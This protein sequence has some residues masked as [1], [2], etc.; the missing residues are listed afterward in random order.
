VKQS[1]TRGQQLELGAGVAQR[2]DQDR[3]GP[4]LGVR[5]QR[6][7][8]LGPHVHDPD[9][10]TRGAGARSTLGKVACSIEA[11]IIEE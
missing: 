5:R 1:L 10:R 11:G 6:L 8:A 9:H 2:P 4:G 7:G 3:P